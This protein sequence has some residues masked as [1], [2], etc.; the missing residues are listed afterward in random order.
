MVMDELALTM[1]SYLTTVQI[2]ID[3]HPF[4]ESVTENSMFSAQYANVQGTIYSYVFF[5][6]SYFFKVESSITLFFFYVKSGKMSSY[7]AYISS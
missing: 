7:H 1:I 6:R 4:L 5:I 2:R 3:D